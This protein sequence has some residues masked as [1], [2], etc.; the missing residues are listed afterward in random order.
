M[1]LEAGDEPR[2]YSECS[3]TET[4]SSMYLRVSVSALNVRRCGSMKNCVAPAALV[5]SVG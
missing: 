4:F 5:I 3:D 2:P 1:A